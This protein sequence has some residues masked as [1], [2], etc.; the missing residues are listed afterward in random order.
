VA[1]QGDASLAECVEGAEVG[2]GVA[3][4]AEEAGGVAGEAVEGAGGA[5]GGG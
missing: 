5:E 3:G 2:G 4:E 1:G